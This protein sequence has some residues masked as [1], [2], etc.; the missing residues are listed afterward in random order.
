MCGSILHVYGERD[1]PLEK[2]SHSLSVFAEA[3]ALTLQLLLFLM[4]VEFLLSYLRRGHAKCLNAHRT[5]TRCNLTNTTQNY[6][7]Q[8]YYEKMLH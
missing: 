8:R 3:S 1:V 2:K 4:P 5:G 7:I 6:L